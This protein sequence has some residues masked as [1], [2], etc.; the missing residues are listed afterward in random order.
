MREAGLA[1]L[2]VNRILGRVAGDGER[3][4]EGRLV[5]EEPFRAELFSVN[6]LERHAK[7]LAGWHEIGRVRKPDLL[8]PRLADNEVVMR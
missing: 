7:S 6:Q 4:R 8:L 2:T 5:Q 1:S 3:L